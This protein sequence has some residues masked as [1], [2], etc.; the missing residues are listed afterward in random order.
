VQAAIGG[1]LL[2]TVIASSS[3]VVWYVRR[4]QLLHYIVIV[5]AEDIPAFTELTYDYGS[6]YIVEGDVCST[7]LRLSAALASSAQCCT[8]WMHCSDFDAALAACFTSPDVCNPPAHALPLYFVGGFQSQVGLLVTDVQTCFTLLEALA[9]WSLL[10]KLLR[11]LLGVWHALCLPCVRSRSRQQQRRQPWQQQEA[12]QPRRG[13]SPA[14][15]AL[16]TAEAGS[17]TDAAA[18][19]CHLV[20][21]LHALSYH[22]QQFGLV[23]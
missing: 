8:V 19:H 22:V 1:A 15:A 18:A 4:S 16:T 10:H 9:C 17:R 5:A 7:Q 12:Q 23:H 14:T 6:S 13:G 20:Q 3:L 2:T 11:D 21:Q